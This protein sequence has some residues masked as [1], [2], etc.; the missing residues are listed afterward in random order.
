VAHGASQGRP[1]THPKI[2]PVL[3]G[4]ERELQAIGG[5]IAAAGSGK[6]TALLLVGDPGID[7]DVELRDELTPSEM[8]AE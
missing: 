4:R 8:V 5:A 2:A 1:T 3:V 6:S 7:R